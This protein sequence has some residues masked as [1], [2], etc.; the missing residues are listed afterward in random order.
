MALTG[1]ESKISF[2][3]SLHLSNEIF[4]LSASVSHIKFVII[5]TVEC[6]ILIKLLIGN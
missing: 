6:I 3:E 1:H 5:L 2:R 4:V